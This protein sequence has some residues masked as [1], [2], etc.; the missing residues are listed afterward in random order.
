M[1]K[2]KK[3]TEIKLS[4]KSEK[5]LEKPKAFQKGKEEKSQIRAELDGD[6]VLTDSLVLVILFLR[7]QELKFSLFR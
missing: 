6:K 3:N 7:M 2:S 1:A 5:G 4:N